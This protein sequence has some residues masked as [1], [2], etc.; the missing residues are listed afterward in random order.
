MNNIIKRVWNQN[1]MVTIEDLRGM[2]FQAEAGGH[3]F[4]ISGIDDQGNAVPLS[5]TVA[6]SFIRPDQ[7]TVALTGTAEDGIVSVTLDEDCYAV[8][9][10]FGLTIFVTD[11][12]DQTVA[13]Y[14]AVGTVSRSSTDAVAG[15]APQDVVD[16]VNAIEAAIAT[17]PADYTDLMAA[18]APTYSNT[19]L[20]AIGSYAWYDGNLYR[21]ISD[22]T[23]AESW[24]AAHWA[25]VALANDVSDLNKALYE[26]LDIT[27]TNGGV[28]V[29]TAT[30]KVSIN[31]N[32]SQRE[33][34]TISVD[35]GSAYR[36]KT[37]VTG[38]TY[39]GITF[40]DDNGN[41]LAQYGAAVG[42]GWELID[43]IVMAPS[44][45]AV[46][47]INNR[48]YST[49]HNAATVERALTLDY[50]DGIKDKLDADEQV[51]DMGYVESG[52]AYTADSSYNALISVAASTLSSTSITNYVTS[53]YPV[54]GGHRYKLIGRNARVNYDQHALAAFSESDFDGT[55]TIS[56]VPIVYG[57]GATEHDYDVDFVAPSNG[58]IYITKYWEYATLLLYDGVYGSA[59]LYNLTNTKLQT[60]KIQ[61]FGDSITDDSWRRNRTTWLT[62]LPDYLTQRTLS[63]K[64]EAVGGSHIGHGHVDSQ[65]GKYHEL[66]YNYVYDLM[67][68]EEIFDPTSDIIVMFVGTNDFNSSPLGA[69]GDNTVNTFYGAARLICEFI[70]QNTD[71]I[72]FVVTPIARPYDVDT[73]KQ[74]NADGER[75]NAYGATLRDYA[76]ALIRTC[77]FYQFPVIDLFHDLGLNKTNVKAYLDDIGVH[78]S[79]KGSNLISAYI[80][81]CLKKHIGI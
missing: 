31:A 52:S 53:K 62:L 66:E 2:A 22:I 57:N 11:E 10:R 38:S 56:C 28:Y 12:D 67:T 37:Y 19:A 35:G 13:V 3:T 9:G 48:N 29:S 78:P 73:E 7:A 74:L 75:V 49:Y 55:D 32:A 68:N 41:S 23:T 65:T 30:N 5:G 44:N 40:A 58:Y 18:I 63:I 69:W 24:T 45:A 51:F 70:S 47:Y 20:Y 6:G 15:S 17:I 14:A 64:N 21:C 43:L 39:K 33:Y 8:A 16:L 71:A 1:R 79:I 54:I 34:A 42:S 26:P 76:N 60:L 4:E 50:V 25:Q 61:A 27:M 77:E 46:L 81:S 36:I 72:F 80:S 59:R